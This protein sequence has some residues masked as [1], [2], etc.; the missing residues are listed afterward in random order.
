ML[1]V[2]AVIPARGGSKGIPGKNIAPLNGKPLLAYTI[3]CAKKANLNG[4]IVV[5]TDS[6]E[7]A[8]IA[9]KYGAQ[10]IRRPAEISGDTAPTESA[11]IHVLDELKKT[12]Y[13]PD[14]IMTLQPTSPMRKAETVRKFVDEFSKVS[15]TYDA[16]LSLHE[17]RT[18]FWVNKGGVFGRLFPNAPRRRQAREPLYAENS[19][20]YITKVNS[21][22]ES[23]SVLGFNPT[24]F[25][26]DEAEALDINEPQDMLLAEF[27]LNKK[28]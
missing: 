19:A 23:G 20:L 28:K 5:S 9:E 17:N 4:P 26:I 12:G 2:L 10:V 6:D 3:E 8:K 25:I 1:S 21:L 24:V 13:L 18:D 16:M 7:I 11:L 14:V 27:L 22:R 15:G